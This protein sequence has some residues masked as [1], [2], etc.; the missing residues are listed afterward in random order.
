MQ[1]GSPQSAGAVARVALQ[2]CT[3]HL[4]QACL[5]ARLQGVYAEAVSLRVL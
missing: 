4:R 1:G 3:H 2:G 5:L